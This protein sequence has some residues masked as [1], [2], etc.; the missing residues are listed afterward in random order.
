MCNI[1]NVNQWNEPIENWDISNVILKYSEKGAVIDSNQN[2]LM[3]YKFL[4]TNKHNKYN[5]FHNDV[6]FLYIPK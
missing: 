3:M 5:S 6:V 4:F 2:S 1:L